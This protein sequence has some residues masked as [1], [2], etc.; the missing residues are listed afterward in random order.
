M[1]VGIPNFMYA[2]VAFSF[3]GMRT[4][5]QSRVI[6]LNLKKPKFTNFVASVWTGNPV[7]ENAEFG[8]RPAA[9]A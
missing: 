7:V 5:I 3:T 1:Q 2:F 6:V 4:H 9:P 8:F